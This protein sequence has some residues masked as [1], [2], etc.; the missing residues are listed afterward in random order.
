MYLVA[1]GEYDL[2]VSRKPKYD[3]DIA[4]G[5]AFFKHENFLLMDIQK[6]NIL[7]NLECLTTKG[8]IGG[9]KRPVEMYFNYIDS[10]SFR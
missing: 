8:V 7:F 5:A 3:W 6:N 9:D 10:S 2:I 4:A 1:C